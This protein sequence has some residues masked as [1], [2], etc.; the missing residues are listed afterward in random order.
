MEFSALSKYA[1]WGT[2][3]ILCWLMS[4]ELAG[5]QR[6]EQTTSHGAVIRGDADQKQLALDRKS[7]V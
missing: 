5:R 4:F 7:V 6:M 2:V 1:A 3:L